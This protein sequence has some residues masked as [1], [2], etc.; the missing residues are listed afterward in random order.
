M[1]AAF[2][3]MVDDLLPR[4]GLDRP[5]AG[6][7]RVWPGLSARLQTA[8]QWL[9][10]Q[11]FPPDLR[12]VR[13]GV[14]ELRWLGEDAVLALYVSSIGGQE[15]RRALVLAALMSTHAPSESL[16][17][18]NTTVGDAGFTL[19]G[20][21]HYF[22]RGNLGAMVR[23]ETDQRTAAT[24]AKLLDDAMQREQT[25]AP[26]ALPGLLPKIA[27][28]RASKTDVPVGETARVTLTIDPDWAGRSKPI[29]D[30]STEL[31]NAD[32]PEEHVAD[33][34]GIEPGDAEVHGCAVEK[35]TLL[36]ATKRVTIT[37]RPGQKPAPEEELEEDAIVD[38]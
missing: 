26:S 19:A 29:F 37:V 3:K 8:L 32:F 4:L 16:R 1:Y 2:E 35:K 33:L 22:S 23:S 25:V 6:S 38:D 30:Y 10:I 14:A 17:P 9:G 36:C 5:R 20:F 27:D 11:A 7:E 31:L 12:L 15:L 34:T 13:P 18:W 24:L 28:L 21:D